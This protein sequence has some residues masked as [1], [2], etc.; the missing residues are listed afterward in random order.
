MMPLA[1]RAQDSESRLAHHAPRSWRK[2]P[3][4]DRLRAVTTVEWPL[5]Q[6]DVKT[7][8]APDIQIVFCREKQGSAGAEDP[9][10]FAQAGPRVGYVLQR[11]AAHHDV[12]LGRAQWQLLDIAANDGRS[13]A[14]CAQVLPSATQGG[15][16]KIQA[17]RMRTIFK[18]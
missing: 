2:H 16:G 4:F 8:E 5:P 12:H 14:I 10:Q 13:R 3:P 7:V 6:G 9:A 15:E 17:E 11:F 18:Q 1:V